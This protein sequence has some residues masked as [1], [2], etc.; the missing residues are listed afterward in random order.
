MA[1]TFALE[2]M[3]F[4]GRTVVLT[5]WC[6]IAVCA[7]LGAK[8]LETNFSVELFIPE[9]SISDKY[10]ELDKRYFATGF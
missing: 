5:I 9:D 4:Q 7:I 2:I 10:L 3:T 8:N 1:T 6:L